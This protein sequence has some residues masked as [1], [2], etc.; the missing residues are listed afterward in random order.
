M[1]PSQ[2]VRQNSCSECQHIKV[3]RACRPACLAVSFEAG[4]NL[5]QA[6]EQGVWREVAVK[7]RGGIY[8]VRPGP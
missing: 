5:V 2:P 1:T 8:V 4:F 3:N 7:C 6:L